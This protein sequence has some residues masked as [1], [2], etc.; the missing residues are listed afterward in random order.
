MNKAEQIRILTRSG[1]S[2]PAIARYLHSSK[3]YV[4]QVRWEMK[5][6]KNCGR[7]YRREWMRERRKDRKFRAAEL[8]REAARKMRA[9]I[10]PEVQKRD[11][12]DRRQAELRGGDAACRRDGAPET[13]C[14]SD[15]D[16]D[17]AAISR[18]HAEGRGGRA[19]ERGCED[20]AVAYRAEEGGGT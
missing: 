10:G 2:I 5:Q 19:G 18:A 6:D 14:V 9:L 17:H 11:Q 7:A 16:A 15:R 8:Q 1:W 20:R 4:Y 12:Y 13:I 3:G